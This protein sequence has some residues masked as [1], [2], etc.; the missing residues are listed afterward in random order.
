MED[1][2]PAQ[3][4]QVRGG[5]RRKAPMGEGTGRGDEPGK[6]EPNLPR[7]ATPGG[8]LLATDLVVPSAQAEKVRRMGGWGGG[9]VER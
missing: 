9:R 7:R 2:A 6:R 8:G 4:L 5:K 1:A 3:I